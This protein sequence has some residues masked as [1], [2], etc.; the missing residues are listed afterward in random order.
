MSAYKII[1]D[2]YPEL[3]DILIEKLKPIIVSFDNRDKAEKFLRKLTE[4]NY[5]GAGIYATL[6]AYSDGFY[7]KKRFLESFDKIIQLEL[8]NSWNV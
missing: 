1:L 5:I 7:E 3:W 2:K 8:D 4:G 6:I